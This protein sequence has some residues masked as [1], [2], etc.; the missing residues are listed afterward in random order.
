MRVFEGG[1]TPL[2]IQRFLITGAI[3][4]KCTKSYQSR[5]FKRQCKLYVIR[6][7]KLFYRKCDRLRGTEKLIEIVHDDNKIQ[8]LMGVAHKGADT[9]KQAIGMSAH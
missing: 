9:S 1:I 6:D 4:E 2:D 5:N 7:N 3:P 8:K